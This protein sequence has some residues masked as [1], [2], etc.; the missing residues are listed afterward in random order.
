MSYAHFR[1]GLV[2]EENYRSSLLIIDAVGRP[3]AVLK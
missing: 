2:P 1:S 3:R